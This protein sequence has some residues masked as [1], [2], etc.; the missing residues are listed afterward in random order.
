MLA[1]GEP[2]GGGEGFGMV[3]VE[4]GGE[5]GVGG[6]GGDGVWAIATAA[7]KVVNSAAAAVMK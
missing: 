4:P 1:T 3:V 5:E 7:E 2:A 6:G